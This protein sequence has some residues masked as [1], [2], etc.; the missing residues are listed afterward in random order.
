[1]KNPKNS[2]KKE[3]KYKNA[4]KEKF[5][6]YKNE[7]DK[8]WKDYRYIEDDNM[9][10]VRLSD[11][12]L[13]KALC[14]KYEYWDDKTEENF[15]IKKDDRGLYF[16]DEYGKQRYFMY[17]FTEEEIDIKKVHRYGFDYFAGGEP[18][19]FGIV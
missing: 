16:I 4:L 19:V 1:M 13:Y 12:A 2:I 7:V 14:D 10:R 15:H 17:P 9:N 3:I 11:R 6:H 5:I 8:D 18:I